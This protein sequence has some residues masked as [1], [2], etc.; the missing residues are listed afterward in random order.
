MS[1]KFNLAQVPK[2]DANSRMVEVSFLFPAGLEGGVAVYTATNQI[3]PMLAF[4]DWQ[5]FAEH[6]FDSAEAFWEKQ[7]W[8]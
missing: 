3:R 5:I 7:K 2:Y 1:E 8:N 4:A 6:D